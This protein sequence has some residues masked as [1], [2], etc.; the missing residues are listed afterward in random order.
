[1]TLAGAELFAPGS[2]RLNPAFEPVIDRIGAAIDELPG[3]V[4]VVGHSDSQPIRSFKYQNNF[5]LSEDR[6][7]SVLRRLQQTV[8]VPARLRSNGV[9]STQPRYVPE[10]EPENRARNRRVEIVHVLSGDT[11]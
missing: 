6:A 3:P 10:D 11:P 7:L 4:L 5:E 1:V 9:G 8:A 2:A